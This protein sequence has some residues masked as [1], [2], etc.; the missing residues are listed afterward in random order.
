VEGAGLFPIGY[1]RRL[2]P[3]LTILFFQG[4][5][6]A[7]GDFQKGFSYYKQGQ[8]AKAIDEFE[9]L[10]KSNPDYEAGYRVL[11]DSYLKLKQ[12]D[13]ASKAFHKAAEL[14]PESLVN[15]MGA[16]I[17]EFNL[18]R[19]QDCVATLLR[20][21]HLAR[22]P[23]E[24]YQLYHLRGSA[25]YNAQ[26]FPEAVADLEKA[27]TL[28]RG[29]YTDVLQL[30]LAYLN[31]GKFAE[32]RKYLEQAVALQP[33]N[34]QAKQYLDRVGYQEALAALGEKRYGEAARTLTRFVQA[35]PDDGEA[36]YNLGLAL[37]FA[38]DRAK[39]EEAFL[40]SARL[41]PSK[42]ETFNRL[43]YVYELDKRYS[44]SLKSYQEALRLHS[45]PSIK[46]SVS[47]VQE[48]IKRQ[49]Q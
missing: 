5:V 21:E 20:A 34:Q 10:V 11:G 37:L 32:A 29:E 16:A 36:W 28:Q 23:K 45:D 24:R 41:L 40:K 3:V 48:R 49:N 13:K 26:R 12:F 8:Y 18:G 2:L 6:W 27:V 42:W 31:L 14:D 25:N 9:K 46:E 7:Q 39:A 15:F 38:E 33:S 43:G 47:R 4:A 35:H 30:G 1:M 44:E 17:A 22:S 19:Y